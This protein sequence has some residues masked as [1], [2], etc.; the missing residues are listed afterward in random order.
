LYFD[1]LATELSV[2]SFEDWYKINVQELYTRGMREEIIHN[3]KN[4]LSK[5]LSVAYPE[6]TF[7]VWKFD[8]VPIGYWD[9]V[10]NQ[11]EFFNHIEKELGIADKDEW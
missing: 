8:K 4:S 5:A 6:H 7:P 10:D 9:N 11:R 1:Q 3:Y 2:K